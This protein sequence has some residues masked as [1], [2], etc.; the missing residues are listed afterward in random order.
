MR[1]LLLSSIFYVIGSIIDNLTTYWLVIVEG[2]FQEA[3][4]FIAPFIYT[5]PLYMWFIRDALFFLLIVAIALGCRYLIDYLSRRD[6][7]ER[8]ARNL[9]IASRWWIIVLVA[10]IARLYP[11]AHN[12]LVLMGFEPPLPNAYNLLISLLGG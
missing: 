4:P 9:K 8:R 2:R 7:P 11:V 6:P 10:S 1:W 3:N 12:C 5:Q